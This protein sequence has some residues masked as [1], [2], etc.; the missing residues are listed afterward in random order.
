MNRLLLVKQKKK[1]NYFF[2]ALAGGGGGLMY[3]LEFLVE[4]SAARFS[5][6]L[7]YFRTNMPFSILFFRPGF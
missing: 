7:Q 3:S 5:E 6:F 4:V 2:N 1:K